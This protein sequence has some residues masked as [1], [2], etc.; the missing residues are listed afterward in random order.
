MPGMGTMA[1]LGLPYLSNSVT[2]FPRS[3]GHDHALAFIAISIWGVVFSWD[4]I[5]RRW[6]KVRRALEAMLGLLLLLG[7][8]TLFG[9]IYYLLLIK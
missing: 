3:T 5:E 2:S 6:P 7:L 4:V 1:L 8:A 9:T